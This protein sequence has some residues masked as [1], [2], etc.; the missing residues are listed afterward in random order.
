MTDGTQNPTGDSVTRG[1]QHRPAPLPPTR[2]STAAPIEASSSAPDWEALAAAGDRA[3]RRRRWWTVAMVVVACMAGSGVGLA[4]M[5]GHGGGTG[6]QAHGAPPG[7]ASPSLPSAS[8]GVAQQSGSIPDHS[9]QI[10][11]ALGQDAQMDNA[12]GSTVLALRGQANSY[13]EA[14]GAVVDV[15]QSF[16]VSAWVYN[17][18]TSD[19]R[20]ALSQGDGTSFSF[21]LG[22]ADSGGSKSW[23]FQIQA[24]G[25]KAGTTTCQVD[26]AKV[27][28]VNQWVLL[29]G[30]YDSTDHTIALYV[31]GVAAG[32]TKVPGIWNAPG[33]LEVGRARDRGLWD[34]VWTGEI[35]HIQVWNRALTPAE[36]AD[37][38]SG[39][40]D[41][42]SK[43]VDSWLVG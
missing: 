39:A 2:Y 18:D 34:Q 7:S 22:R 37:I 13:G 26:S 30:T 1:S 3:R 41:L 29:T 8:P 4:V 19:P 40:P 20:S 14:A 35:G 36:A 23:Q 42:G 43:P 38:K 12:N 17:D 33:P 6:P 15:T 32:S 21:N 16:T 31:D 28:T 24:G 9:G 10:P 25:Q 27:G 11:L 5:G